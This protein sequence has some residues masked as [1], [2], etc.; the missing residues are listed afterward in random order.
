MTVLKEKNNTDN[1]E[2]CP[3]LLAVDFHGAEKNGLCVNSIEKD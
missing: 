1:T 3:F 2:N